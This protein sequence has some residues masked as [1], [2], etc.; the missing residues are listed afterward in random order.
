L[1]LSMSLLEYQYFPVT[2]PNK[3]A[4]GRTGAWRIVKPVVDYNK[5]IGCKV[6][7]MFCPESTIV[8]SNG[9]VRVDYEYCKG[10][11]VCANVCPVKAISMVNEQ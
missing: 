8:P 5:C 10:C 4:G 9:K 6:C 11:G 2:R 7:F 1:V 3:G